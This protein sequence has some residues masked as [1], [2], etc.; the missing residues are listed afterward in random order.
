LVGRAVLPGDKS[1]SHRALLFSAIA[2]GVSRLENILVAGV[3]SAMMDCLR[4]LGVEIKIERSGEEA[5]SAADL[6]VHGRG[7]RGLNEPKHH[8][9]CRGSATTMRLMAGVLAGQQFQ[10]T[11]DGNQRLRLRPMDRVVTPLREKGARIQT[12]KGNAPLTFF[13][14]DLQPSEHFLTVASAQ[15]KSALLLAGLFSDGPT[16]VSEPSSSRDHTERMLRSLGVN[17]EEWHDETG[18]HWVKMAGG[19]ETL[20]GLDLRLPSDPSSAAFLAVAATLVPD[21]HVRI[22]GVCVNPGRSGLF[23]VLTEMGGRIEMTPVQGDH[24]EPSADLAVSS[25]TLSGVTVGGSTV[26]AMIDEFPIFAV[27][28]TQAHGDTVV[29]DAAE[30]RLKESDRIDALVG[31][32]RTMGANIESAEDGFVVRGPSRLKGA[33]VNARGDH[34]LAMSLAVAGLVADGETV[35]HGWEIMNDSFPEFP[36]VLKQLGADVRW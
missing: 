25:Q 18:R 36:Q 9:D 32:L 12:H 4:E 19:V 33:A 3:T 28:A 11:L 2:D 35:V 1:V 27:A 7:L 24:A 15:V 23:S 13:P 31:E 20:P 6:V 14:S 21:S 26:P 10:S 30:L 34:R 17:L 16:T 22:P 29:R 8:L 5:A